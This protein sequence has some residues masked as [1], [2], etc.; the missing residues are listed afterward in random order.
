MTLPSFINASLPCRR[1]ASRLARTTA[2]RF[3]YAKWPGTTPSCQNICWLRK[4]PDCCTL[5]RTGVSTLFNTLWNT[6][7]RLNEG[8]ALRRRDF[9]LNESI[10]HVVLRTAKQRRAGGGRPRKGKVPTGWCRYRTR[11]MSMRCAGCSPARRSSLKMI[12]LQANVARNRCGMFP[13]GRCVTGWSGLLMPR[14]V[15]ASD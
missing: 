1:Q 11:P 14:I 5:F 4:W 8:L 10:P 15:T 9:H 12:R 6:G 13:T 2:A 7:A 3:R